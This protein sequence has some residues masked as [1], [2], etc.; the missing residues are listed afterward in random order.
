MWKPGIKIGPNNW[1]Q[2][3]TQS[4]A[5]YCEVW[6]NVTTPQIYQDMFSFL[7]KRGVHTGLHFWGTLQDNLMPNIAYP[8]PNILNPTINQIK[9]TIDFAATWGFFYVNIH[10]GAS[11]LERMF[12][13]THALEP[14][15]GSQVPLEKAEQTSLETLAIL[16]DYADKKNVLLIVETV[17]SHNAQNYL[18]SQ[19]RLHNV[20]PTHALSSFVIE[21]AAKELGVAVNNDL[22]HTGAVL[23]TESR[24]ELWKFLFDRTQKLA[25][26]TKLIHSNTMAPP[27]NGTDSHDGILDEDFNHNVFPNKTQF[28]SLLHLFSNRDDVWVVNEPQNKHVE[29]YNALRAFQ[30]SMR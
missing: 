26:Y 23:V 14:V 25:P 9:K 1:E 17:P 7:K 11:S 8:S 19:A 30:S 15:A 12:F 28:T 6:F 24:E 16:Q 13:E 10:I 29:N 5:E 18:D 21:K 3:I 22:S 2:N 27:F 20:F 4:N